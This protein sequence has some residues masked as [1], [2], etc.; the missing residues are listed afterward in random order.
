[1]KQL[2]YSISTIESLNEVLHSDEIG[3]S[4][5][6]H[7]QLIQIFS[8]KND[9]E[10]FVA[11]GDAIR[12]VFPEATV[13][14][15]SSVGEIKD[16]KLYTDSTIVAFSFFDSSSLHV[17]SYECLAGCEDVVGKSLFNDIDALNFGV[18]GVLLL[19]NPVNNDSSR[20][21]NSFTSCGLS[22][23][24]FGGGAGDYANM[25]KTLVY[26][27]KNCYSQGVVAVVF[28]GEN[29]FI[30]PFTYL[31]WHPLSKEMTVTEVDHMSLKKIDGC[32][33]FSVF[34]N[35]LDVKYNDSF[36]QNVLEFPLLIERNGQL[37]AR[38]PFFVNEK[39]DSIEFLADIKEGEKFRIG[40]GNP[41]TI[42]DESISIQDQMFDFQPDAILLYTCICRRFLMQQDVEFETEPFN[43][44]A[45]TAGFYTFGEFFANKTSDALL[46]STMVA[47]GFR[48]GEKSKEKKLKKY[49]ALDGFR[50]SED[51][52]E[53]KH[54]RILSQLLYFIDATIKELEEQNEKLKILNEQ[55]N[56]FLG[57]AAHDLRNPLGAIHGFSEL[58]EEHLSDK[59]KDYASMIVRE[60]SKMLQLLNDLLDIS[61]IE[62][63]KLDLKKTENEYV[64][65]VDN[66]IKI[67]SFLAQ[68]KKII[69]VSEFG[70]KKQVLSIDAG[71]IEQV[72][73][74]LI[75][76][77][78]KFSLPGSVIRVKI[79]KKDNEIVTQVIDQGQGIPKDE[80]DILFNPFKKTS[81]LP[82]GRE[83][84]HGLGLAIVKKV[85]EG[86][87]GTVS[88]AS[89]LGKGSTFS[90]SLPL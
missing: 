46:N 32:P 29:L 43:L 53:N 78:I 80:I 12:C 2:N 1:M 37:V 21:F 63:G 45:P 67:N 15:A 90:F 83:S 16:G 52:F 5:N 72:L 81:V 62:A 55:K 17:F 22:Y 4:S 19:S 9:K 51:P 34:K 76:N 27:G 89:E 56:E 41:R 87:N 49:A 59:Y 38:V 65:L 86:H 69:L 57:I 42:I 28:S 74:N 20:F 10:W 47:V 75:S 60:S 66:N 8:A 54:T 18:R 70:I 33:A 79:F 44:I 68:K 88:V 73:N 58:L 50:L 35:Y 30:E 39:D 23:P 85:V 26:D 6:S 64:G 24:V 82:T 11:L 84:S 7:S 25:R 61:K 14:G 3:M 36:F 48:E 71:K 13:V 77:A 31:G 40:Y